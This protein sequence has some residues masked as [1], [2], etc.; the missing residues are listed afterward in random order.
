MPLFLVTGCAT[1]EKLAE[2]TDPIR[3]QLTQLEQALRAAT[4]TAQDAKAEAAANKARGDAM[5][6]R[7]ESLQAELRALQDKQA[8]QAAELAER[9]NKAELR[10]DEAATTALS[11]SEAVAELQAQDQTE[12]AKLAERMNKSELRLDEVATATLTASE[13][14]AELQSQG[15][16]EAAKLAELAERMNKSELRLDEVATAA[17]NTSEATAALQAQAQG[18]AAEHAELAERVAQAEKRV[19]TLSAQMAEALAASRQ[20]YIRTHGKVVSTAKL[21]DDKTLYPLNSPELGSGDRAKLDELAARLKTLEGDYH[22]DIQGHTDNIG[23]DDYNY[24]LG[25][26][27]VEVVKR[28]LH[29][30]GGIPLSRM[31]VI[32]YGAT[33]PIAAGSQGNRR[34][35]VN[36][37]VLEK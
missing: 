30:R 24:L 20:D 3:Q 2:Q 5:T 19:E 22:L 23:T 6:G 10:L 16:A 15:Q 37:L 14:A 31:S 4:A 11:T 13:A 36:L 1:Q 32:S 33:N 34:I 29:E 28:Y 35:L 21:T 25:K 27:R 18:G 8:L 17:I 9:M 7:M 26:A 12:A